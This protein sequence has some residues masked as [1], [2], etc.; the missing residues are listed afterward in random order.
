MSRNH[1]VA[2]YSNSVDFVFENCS[3]YVY[4][5][6][7]SMSIGRTRL[8]SMYLVITSPDGATSYDTVYIDGPYG[9]KH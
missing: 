2:V 5:L 3:M 6:K 7:P 4:F 1:V 8:V 9:S